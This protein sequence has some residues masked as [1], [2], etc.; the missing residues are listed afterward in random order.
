MKVAGQGWRRPSRCDH[1]TCVEV[2]D[3]GDAVSLRNSQFPDR[4]RLTFPT[5][6]WAEFIAAVRR[7]EFDN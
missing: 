2:R 7:G 4:A 6:A 3:Y 1:S 5:E